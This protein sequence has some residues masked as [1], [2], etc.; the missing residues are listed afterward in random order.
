[1]KTFKSSLGQVE[2]SM[3]SSFQPFRFFDLPAELRRK[4][5][6]LVLVCE[7]T[8]DN[9]CNE[10]RDFKASRCVA[11]FTVSKRF[12]E[13]AALAFYGGNTFRLL[14]TQGRTGGKKVKPLIAR[15][16]PRYR[17]SLNSLELRLGPFWT[18]P[19]KCWEI[20]DA[21][22]LEDAT[23]VRK[24]RVFVEI[25]PSHHALEGFRGGS[26]NHYTFFSGEILKAVIERLPHL[27]EIQFDGYPSV[28]RDGSLMMRLLQETRRG[29]K[30]ITWGPGQNF[31]V[32][33]LVELG[34]PL[35]PVRLFGSMTFTGVSF[36]NRRIV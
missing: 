21:L 9:N 6:S 23:A 34:N 22:G 35:H 13:E 16:H 26:R 30:T 7:R 8:L 20:N 14:P 36:S 10:H 25:D 1:M 28:R 11:T 17:P 29:S 5:L 3:R 33:D 19:P 24:L 32:I 18:K 4:I 12:H 2:T 27:H 31:E 15:F